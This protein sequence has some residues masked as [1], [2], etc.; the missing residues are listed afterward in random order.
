MSAHPCSVGSTISR[1]ISR[2]SSPRLTTSP[3]RLHH[4]PH[5]RAARAQPPSLL[6]PRSI[7]GHLTPTPSSTT[8]LLPPEGRGRKPTLHASLPSRQRVFHQRQRLPDSASG[9]SP[10]ADWSDV[11]SPFC[12]LLLLHS[13]AQSS[14]MKQLKFFFLSLLYPSFDPLSIYVHRDLHAP[15]HPYVRVCHY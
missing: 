11:D 4:P 7:T 6:A 12:P 8:S 3:H 13:T 9:N 2:S 14:S 10:D 15:E 1:T 5:R